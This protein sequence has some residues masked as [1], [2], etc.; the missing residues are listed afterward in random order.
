M[1]KIL[2]NNSTQ[3]KIKAGLK[4]ML[5]NLAKGGFKRIYNHIDQQ[6]IKNGVDNMGID[7]FINQCAMLAA[8]S[9]VVTGFGG[10]AT[11]LVGVP[12]DMTN[13]V[14][15]QFRVT[16]A[17]NYYKTGRSKVSF[18]ELIGII[19][20]SLKVDAGIAISKKVMEEVAEKL[21]LAI[22]TRTARRLVPVVGAVIGGSTNYLFIKKVAKDLMD[23]QEYHQI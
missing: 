20:S 2:P 5:S 4:D 6:T 21:L 12:L 9:G 10:F 8:G 7:G 1:L 17:I 13:L 3:D 18:I 23:K 16:M 19:A 15:Q 14:A 11:M 22:G